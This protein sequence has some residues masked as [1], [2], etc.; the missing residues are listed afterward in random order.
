MAGHGAAGEPSGQPI[1]VTSS[2]TTPLERP[3]LP[4]LAAEFERLSVHQLYL[5]A[6]VSAGLGASFTSITSLGRLRADKRLY[7]RS[8]VKSASGRRLNTSHLDRKKLKN[9]TTNDPK[10]TPIA[11]AAAEPLCVLTYAT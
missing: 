10:A 5:R 2:P 9:M 4:H 7:Y 3:Y 8:S 1:G 6:N 11:G